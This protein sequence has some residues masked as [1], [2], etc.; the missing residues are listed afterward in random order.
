MDFEEFVFAASEHR[1]E[2]LAREQLDDR[3]DPEPRES[4]IELLSTE[5]D[6]V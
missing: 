2:E 1:A 6:E 3:D 5:E 4:H